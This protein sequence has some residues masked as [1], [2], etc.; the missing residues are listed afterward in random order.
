MIDQYLQNHLIAYIG[1]K[2]R[3]L[4]LIKK[5]IEKTGVKG[6][7]I[8]FLDLFAGSGAVSRLAKSM[9]FEVYCNDWEYYSYII[10]KAFLEFDKDFLEN[11]F[12]NFCGIENVLNI[13]NNLKTP[14]E[15]DAY[16]SKYYCPQDDKNPDLDNDRMF[17]TSYNGKKIDAIRAKIEEW[18]NNNEINEN[19]EILLLALLL[20]EASTRSN[21]S[22]VFKAFHRGFGGTNGDAL[23]RILKE[24]ELTI[25]S[26]INGPKSYVFKE[27]AIELSLMLK[28]INFDIVYLDPPYNQHQ[29]GSNYH[30]LNTIALNDKPPVNERII[31]NGKKVNKSAIRRDWIKTKSSFCYPRSA[32]D[33]F[34]KIINNIS[35]KYI[36]VSY[37]TDGIIDFEDMLSILSTRGKL[38]IILSEYTKYRGGKQSLTTEIKNIEFVLFV[39][40]SKKS[41]IKDIENVQKNILVNK[42]KLIAKKRINL[43]R[44][45]NIGFETNYS[46]KFGEIYL[47]KGYNN[48]IFDFYLVKNKITNISSF[49]NLFNFE[50][51]TLLNIYEDLE[52]ITNLT[53]EDELYIIISDIVKYYLTNDY[54]NVCD[55]FSNIPYLLSKFNN[56]KAYISSLKAIERV[57]NTIIETKNIWINLLENED[58]NELERIILKKLNYSDQNTKE[59]I[60]LKQNIVTLYEEIVQFFEYKNSEKEIK[61]IKKELLK[62]NG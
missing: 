55:S 24:V 17:W 44:A 39:D 3:L 37:S 16:I 45:E 35:S 28:C 22:G 6:D 4:P 1:N 38:D 7:N 41:D 62:I 34:Q 25:P 15:K 43:T 56:K 23:S 2:R 21:T 47:S 59:V 51:K 13:L 26:L 31:I 46:K 42:I 48:K 33:D 29:Y 10:N 8:K 54:K 61:S 36:L 14:K 30:L 52:F 9:G 49:D 27:D 40:T 12:K 20:Y 19:E 11:S 5:A 18:K 32:K 50:L 53:K 58:F 57:L 60:D